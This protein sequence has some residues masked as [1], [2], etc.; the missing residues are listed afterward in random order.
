M[1]KSTILII[2]AVFAVSVFVVGIFGLK[3]V[4]YN[5]I[6]YVE[7]IK[8]TSV[9]LSTS[10]EAPEIKKSKSGYYYVVIPY[11]K[12]IQFMITYEVVPNDA[13]NRKLDVTLENVNKNS[14]GVIL[15]SGAIQLRNKGIVR[16]TY[17]ATDSAAGPTMEFLIY[18]K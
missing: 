11:V 10:D 6:V 12:D 1:K 18:T 13:T 3:N 4:P 5:E 14:D 9:I 7:E 8:P 15:D 16:V 17:R 2:V